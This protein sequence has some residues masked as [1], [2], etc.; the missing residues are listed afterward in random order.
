[1]ANALYPAF[2]EALLSGSVDLTAMDVKAL[3]VDTADYT[4]SAAHNDYNDVPAGAIVDES[5][6]LQ[7]PTITNG[8]LDADDIVVSSVT[9]DQF[10]AIIL[11]VILSASPL[12][13]LLMAYLD[14]GYAN[15]PCTPDGGDVTI[16]WPSDA[17]KIFSL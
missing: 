5:G 14:T 17:N 8:I 10:E 1:M 16:V 13:T 3:L 9:G 15:L 6:V 7:N 11:Y 2:K 4:Y 12:S